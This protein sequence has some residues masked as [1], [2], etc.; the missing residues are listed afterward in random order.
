[1][2]Q[3]LMESLLKMNLLEQQSLLS[4]RRFLMVTQLLLLENSIVLVRESQLTAMKM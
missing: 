1:M 4:T 3:V 2:M